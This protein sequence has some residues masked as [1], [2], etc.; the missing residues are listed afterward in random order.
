MQM[1]SITSC[2]YIPTLILKLCD[3]SLRIL[4]IG[5]SLDSHL[6]LVSILYDYHVIFLNELDLD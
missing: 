6:N 2:E 3:S 4:P 5:V 1:L